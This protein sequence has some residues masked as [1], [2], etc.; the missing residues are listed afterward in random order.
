MANRYVL[1]G[2][3]FYIHFQGL[4]STFFYD[5]FNARGLIRDKPC[6]FR[7]QVGLFLVKKRIE[8]DCDEN[9]I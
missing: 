9:S 2:G 6:I 1:F 8:I 7:K 5:F 3:L 4:D